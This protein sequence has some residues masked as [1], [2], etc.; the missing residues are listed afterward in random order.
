MTCR[1]HR[2]ENRKRASFPGCDP[3]PT[4]FLVTEARQFFSSTPAGVLPR[5]I[6]FSSTSHCCASLGVARAGIRVGNPARRERF[7]S[8][9][10][11]TLSPGNIFAHKTP[12]T[13][14]GSASSGFVELAG[15]ISEHIPCGADDHCHSCRAPESKIPWGQLRSGFRRRTFPCPSPATGVTCHRRDHSRE[16]PM[17]APEFPGPAR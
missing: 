4:I 3:G 5:T 9:F 1:E 11:C 13:V 14:S 2:R 6:G 12:P 7:P 15:A 8:S 10:S 16:F 17:P